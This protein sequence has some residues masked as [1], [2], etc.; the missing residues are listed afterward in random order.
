[1]YADGQKIA[2]WQVGDTA[3]YLAPLPAEATKKGGTITI[4]LRTPKAASPK[5]AGVSADPRV[6]GVC[7]HYIQLRKA[8]A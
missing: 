2:E 5:S 1:V 8:Q 6:L 3:E 4:E 7:V